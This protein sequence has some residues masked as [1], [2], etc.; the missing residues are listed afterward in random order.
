[1]Q[2]YI[3]LT[4]ETLK[5]DNGSGYSVCQ[6]LKKKLFGRTNYL[7]GYN[8]VCL[9]AST[10]NHCEPLSKVSKKWISKNCPEMLIFK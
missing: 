9:D 1:M 5:S 6:H 3:V 4:G 10:I 8:G 7:I 2:K